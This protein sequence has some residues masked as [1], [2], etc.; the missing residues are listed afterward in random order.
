MSFRC[1]ADR[2]LAPQ[3]EET[4]PWPP[5]ILTSGALAPSWPAP[6]MLPGSTLKAAEP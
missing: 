1:L 5:V 2:S 6:F 4:I 3:G